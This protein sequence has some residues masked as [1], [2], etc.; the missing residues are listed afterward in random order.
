MCVER[1][2]CIGEEGMKRMNLIYCMLAPVFFR[3]NVV[4]QLLP[5]RRSNPFLLFLSHRAIHLSGSV[6]VL[7]VRQH[8][9]GDWGGGEG[10][11]GREGGWSLWDALSYPPEDDGAAAAAS[12][13]LAAGGGGGVCGRGEGP[14]RDSATYVF[15]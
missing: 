12:S 13:R 14:P 15:V 5:H 4:V 2:A 8:Y 1:L 7:A 11:G 6:H 3:I 9:G 10:R